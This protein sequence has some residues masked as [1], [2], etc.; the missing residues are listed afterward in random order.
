MNWLTY[1]M[2]ALSLVPYVV[3]GIE[4]IH[5]DAKSGAEKKQLAMESLG[6]AESVAGVV[7]PE[8]QPAIDAATSLVSNAI[9]GTVAV[10][11]ATK[12]V[13]SNA[14]VAPKVPGAILDAGMNAAGAT[15]NN[16]AQSTQS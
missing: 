1:V 15:P 2:K 14:P 7:D 12:S 6:L 10:M 5:G 9:D 8:H 11:N 13:S 4:S 16:P 3:H